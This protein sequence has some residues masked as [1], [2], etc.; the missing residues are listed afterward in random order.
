MSINES[1]GPP[2]LRRI[3]RSDWTIRMGRS[4]FHYEGV[5]K[6]VNLLVTGQNCRCCLVKFMAIAS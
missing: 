4:V 1:G 3:V 5:T 6:P 2:L